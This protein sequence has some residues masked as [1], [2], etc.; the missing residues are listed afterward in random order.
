M[1]DWTPHVLARFPE[2][3]FGRSCFSVVAARADAGWEIVA[4]RVPSVWTSD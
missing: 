1:C 4:L 3:W 2:D